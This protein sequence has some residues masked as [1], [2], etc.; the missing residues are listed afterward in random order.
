MKTMYSFETSRIDYAVTRRHVP[1]EQSSQEGA[2]RRLRE[3]SCL[4]LHGT[5]FETDTATF[6]RL[7]QNTRR[8]FP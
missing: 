3:T 8:Y 1:N 7:Y 6:V 4:Q 2:Y 5:R